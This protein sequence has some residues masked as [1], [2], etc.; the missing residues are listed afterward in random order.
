MKTKPNQLKIHVDTN[1][2]K[3]VSQIVVYERQYKKH[4]RA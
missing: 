1:N 2:E 4:G 3:Q